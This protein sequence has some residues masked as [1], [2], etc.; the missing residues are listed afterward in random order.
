MFERISRTAGPMSLV[1]VF[2]LSGGLLSPGLANAQN[3]TIHINVG[4]ADRSAAGNVSDY[5]VHLR[6]PNIPGADSHTPSSM[7]APTPDEDLSLANS[8]AADVPTVP[9]V[10]A[11]GF[12]P[13]DVSNPNNH[14]VVVSAQSNNLY[15][16][17]PPSEWGNPA[18]FLQNFGMSTFIHVLD[19]YVGS[20]SSGRYTVGLGASLS[21]PAATALADND[22]LQIVHAGAATFGSGYSHIYHV[23]L[24]K[25]TD[26]CFT[27]TTQCYSP[28]N[29]STFAFCA[30]HSSVTFSDIGHVLF[31]VQ[32]YQ[33]V[34]GC[35]VVQ[36]SPNGPLI[37]S[38]A[39]SL[40]HELSETIS[41]PNLNAW[42]VRNE[43]ILFGEE[44][45]DT[46][47]TP[48]FGYATVTLN[49]TA[50]EIQPEYSN[51]YHA[52]AFAP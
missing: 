24:P 40:S 9:V 34:K 47:A 6:T 39:N 49:G 35:R 18:T 25:G 38:T 4:S 28:D 52:C 37:D 5:Q 42:Y 27:G 7:Q 41:D 31:T 20:T 17:S 36:P 16:N 21:Y 11:P 45:G 10:P 15:V 12:Y 26:V 1:A 46:C 23:F 19:Q 48:N 22:I 8:P 3:Q 50:Y 30:Y 51:T 2:A 43:L 13:A 14:K 44:I 33:D 32:P 29:P